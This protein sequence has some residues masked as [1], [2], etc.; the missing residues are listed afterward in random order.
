[1]NIAS[2]GIGLIVAFVYGWAITLVI[3][4]FVPFIIV[5]GVLQTKMLTGFSTKDKEVLQDAGKV[6]I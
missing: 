3:L 6:A 2:L 1:M 4:A 5:S